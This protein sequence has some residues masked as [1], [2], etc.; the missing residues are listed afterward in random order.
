MVSGKEASDAS[1]EEAEGEAAEAEGNPE[2]AV[3]AEFPLPL[4]L[5]PPQP[6]AIKAIRRIAIRT[7][8][9]FRLLRMFGFPQVCSFFYDND[10]HYRIK[11]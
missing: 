11:E 3:A 5:L 10:F 7:V 2:D 1:E 9:V 8:N 4:P 6:A